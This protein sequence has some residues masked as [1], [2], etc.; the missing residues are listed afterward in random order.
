MLKTLA[1]AKHVFRESLRKKILFVLGLFLLILLVSSLFLEAVSPGDRVKLV[2]R[3]SFGSLA[4]FGVMMAIFLSATS[5]PEEI[6]GKL[7]QVV[8]TKPVGRFNFLLGKILGFISVLALLFLLMGTLS[9]ALVQITAGGQP[10]PAERLFSPQ[11]LTFSG[12]DAEGIKLLEEAAKA[13]RISWLWGPPDIRA[14]WHWEGLRGALPRGKATF[15]VINITPAGGP[16]R[17]EVELRAYSPSGVVKVQEIV[18][19]DGEPAAFEFE[20]G[21]AEGEFRVEVRRLNPD[22]AIGMEREGLKIL[23]PPGS[24]HLNFIK[25]LLLLFFKLILMVVITVM[26]STFLSAAVTITFSLFIYLTGHMIEFL[27]TVLGTIVAIS[28]Q[29][30]PCPCPHGHLEA[31]EHGHRWLVEVFEF[32][33]RWFTEL[34]PNLR[35]FGGSDFLIEGVD[36]PLSLLVGS[37]FYMSIYTALA[38]IIAYLFFRRKEFR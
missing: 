37:L 11:S 6:E 33:L 23:A 21:E 36:I 3:V 26:G 32:F 12:E 27:K 4:F 9:W 16:R 20:P 22:F 25:C 15:R 7:I 38:L 29:V 34:F 13:G 17:T 10:L 35:R 5:L 31:E 2:L 24:F 8:M 14:I 19:E 1:V 18:V 30:A 28:A